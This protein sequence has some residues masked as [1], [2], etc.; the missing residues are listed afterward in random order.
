MKLPTGKK[1]TDIWQERNLQKSFEDVKQLLS[2]ACQLYH[3][4][5]QAPIALTTDASKEAMGGV[6][7]QFID[8]AWRPLSFWSKHLKPSEKKWST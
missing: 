1:F 8:G 7:E 3:P 2:N 5:P 4:D 6:L